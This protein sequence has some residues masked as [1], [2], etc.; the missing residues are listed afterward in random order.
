MSTYNAKAVYMETL[1]QELYKY[2]SGVNKEYQEIEMTRS[3]YRDFLTY[4]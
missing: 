3:I 2:I 4:F 1:L